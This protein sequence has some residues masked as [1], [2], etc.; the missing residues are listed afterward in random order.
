MRCNKF[1]TSIDCPRK[2][3]PPVENGIKE[4]FP[5]YS[6]SIN[7]KENSPKKTGYILW[8]VLNYMTYV[9]K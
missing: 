3:H 8:I 4:S 5:I 7:V 9:R 1:A 2:M 6:G